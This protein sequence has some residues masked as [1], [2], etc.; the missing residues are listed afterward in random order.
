M[1]CDKS[2]S[3]AQDKDSFPLTSSFDKVELNRLFTNTPF[4]RGCL[5]P[6]MVRYH[7]CIQGCITPQAIH[8]YD[9]V[10]W[11][12]ILGFVEDLAT[13]QHMGDSHLKESAEV[14]RRQHVKA[15]EC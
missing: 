13:S 3:Y 2:L 5:L 7:Q 15:Q 11:A 10:R 6:R 9:M 14:E 4:R 8:T 1:G 12:P